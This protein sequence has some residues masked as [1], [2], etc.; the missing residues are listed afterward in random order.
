MSV[1]KE[2]L[3]SC[4]EVEASDSSGISLTCGE[5][6]T[7]FLR[8]GVPPAVPAADIYRRAG[9]RIGGTGQSTNSSSLPLS[10]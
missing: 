10:R 3:S 9:I 2:V 4:D 8:Q 7:P 5:K 6:T 1:W